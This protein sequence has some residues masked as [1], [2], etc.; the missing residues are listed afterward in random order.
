MPPAGLRSRKPWIGEPSPS[1]PSSSTLVFGSSTKTVWTPCSGWSSTGE[2]EAPSTSRY[3]RAAA[4]RSGTA[5]A[6]WLRRPIIP[7]LRVPDGCPHPGPLPRYAREKESDPLSRRAS[8]GRGL[9]GGRS[10]VP[11]PFL[12]QRR[13]RGRGQARDLDLD[14][15]AAVA[16]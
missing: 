3:W 2:T 7:L 4:S 10:R 16:G 11:L 6:T 9:G 12:L 5:I 15:R 14:D 1:T 8:D 13:E